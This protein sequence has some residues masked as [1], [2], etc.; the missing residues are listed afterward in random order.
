MAVGGTV[1]THEQPAPE[2]K[3]KVKIPDVCDAFKVAWTDP[4]SMYRTLGMRLVA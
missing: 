4:F 3:R 1:V 2:A